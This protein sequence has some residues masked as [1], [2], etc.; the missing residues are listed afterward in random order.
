MVIQRRRVRNTSRYIG[1]ISPGTKVVFGITDL[2]RFKDVIAKIGFPDS[3]TESQTILPYPTG[4]VS[5]F[6]A[7][8]KAIP[9]KDK[10]KETVYHSVLWEHMEWHGPYQVPATDV[11]DRAYERYPRLLVPPPSIELS[12]RKGSDGNLY[13]TTPVFRI[14]DDNDEKVRHA[15][16]LLLEE[17]GECELLTEDLV[18]HLGPEKLIRLNWD[19][20]PPGE[21]PWEQLKSHLDPIIKKAPEAKQP[22][23]YHRI[24][25][26]NALK[27]DFRATGRGGFHGYI[28][29][30]FTS[31]NVYVLESAYYGNATYVLDERWEALSKMT[32][33]EI[34]RESLQKARIVHL[35]G[36]DE[37]VKE[38]INVK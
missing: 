4:P 34:L 17:F 23:I 29:H 15:I 3:L 25:T 37:K 35:K 24:E 13:L 16:N 20:L 9:Q 7:E 14:S 31:K 11:I 33:A 28:V 32:K 6:N 18:P 19:I 12:I 36:W 1:H 26:V 8:G 30:G 5:L 27:P 38:I 2:E 21:M 10:P 22:L